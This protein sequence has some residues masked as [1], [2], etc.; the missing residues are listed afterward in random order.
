MAFEN[1]RGMR[2]VFISFL[3]LF[4]SAAY[5][6]ELPGTDAEFGEPTAISSQ[7]ADFLF[8]LEEA[9][10]AIGWY[11]HTPRFTPTEEEKMLVLQFRVQ[12]MSD[13]DKRL[14][15]RE[16]DFTAFDPA[17]IGYDNFQGPRAAGDTDELETVLKP[18]QAVDVYGAVLVP[19]DKE[20]VKL[21]V[22]ANP[23]ENPVLR[24]DLRG[25]IDPLPSELSDNG[26]AVRDR[27]TGRVGEKLP[28][29]G[30]DIKVGEF[31]I[32]D[33]SIYDGAGPGSGRVWGVLPM[34]ITSRYHDDEMRLS[35][36]NFDP[37]ILVEDGGGQIESYG[38]IA[39]TSDRRFD[40]RPE[41]GETYRMRLL[42]RMDEAAEPEELRLKIRM[43]SRNEDSHEF[44]IPL[45]GGGS[46]VVQAR[47]EMVQ[48]GGAF[49]VP[50]LTDLDQVYVEGRFAVGVFD[51]EE[52]AVFRITDT[53]EAGGI[54]EAS[55]NTNP[56][57]NEPQPEDLSQYARD[58]RLRLNAISAG[59][60]NESN[61]D[62]VTFIFG[63]FSGIQGDPSSARVNVRRIEGRAGEGNWMTRT[64]TQYFLDEAVES[65]MIEV[66]AY[67]VYGLAVMVLEQDSSSESERDEFVSKFQRELERR[68]R[69]GL[70]RPGI[71][72][73]NN[74]DESTVG[75]HARGLRSVKAA[76]N[77]SRTVEN[78]GTA[79]RRIQ[80]DT[81][82]GLD[83]D[84]D[85]IGVFTT[86][87][88]NLPMLTDREIYEGGLAEGPGG[89]LLA[90]GVFWIELFPEI[91][92][93]TLNTFTSDGAQYDIQ[94]EHRVTGG[95]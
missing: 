66:P 20:I 44:R 90:P 84:D 62:E 37:A 81:T 22:E 2:G 30:F 42:Y 49:Q 4:V 21:M 35:Y 39:D 86:L 10:Y 83:D 48:G 29:G 67:T 78:L 36:R 6:Q 28:V 46:E 87:W 74:A 69:A 25:E 12:N 51:P 9:S 65:L 58:V 26:Y 41:A 70:D 72:V 59:E 53:T 57:N 88:I 52:R 27:L 32:T 1:R 73:A 89:S 40:V 50:D 43:G 34:E 31:S 55:G 23:G 93:A 60:L 18:N 85:Y 79:A 56:G 38:M 68:L 5:G 8:T 16:F 19:D 17:G 33:D 13:T 64:A 24:Y 76:I 14:S 3:F 63:S 94:Y 75:S 45:T 61:G 54:P 71:P 77:G 11:K 7:S 92:D 15:Y 91:R 47:D 80:E 82:G 95:N